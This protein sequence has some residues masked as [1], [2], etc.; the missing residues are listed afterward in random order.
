[1]KGRSGMTFN[2]WDSGNWVM[3][4]PP[5]SEMGGAASSSLSSSSTFSMLASEAEGRYV[6]VRSN[7]DWEGESE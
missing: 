7:I 4:A 5:I 2:V 6:Q 1:M 3:W